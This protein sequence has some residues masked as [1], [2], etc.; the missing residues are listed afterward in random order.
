MSP[1]T[2]GQTYFIL[3]LV[4]DTLHTE[5]AHHPGLPLSHHPGLPVPLTGHPGLS[6][7]LKWYLENG[8]QDGLSQAPN[9]GPQAP[10]T[11]QM[12][13]GVEDCG[14]GLLSWSGNSLHG[15]CYLLVRTFYKTCFILTS[16]FLTFCNRRHMSEENQIALSKPPLNSEA[17]PCL[18]SHLVALRSKRNLSLSHLC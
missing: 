15:V 14:T 4:R 17:F 7:H 10:R 12:L 2:K 9:F 3:W 16:A 13:N 18:Q 6:V 8:N 1:L 5:H 11:L